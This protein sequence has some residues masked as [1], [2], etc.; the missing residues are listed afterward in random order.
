MKCI[1][2][3]IVFLTASA[4]VSAESAGPLFLSIPTETGWSLD[5][6][7]D[8]PEGSKI[9]MWSS[10]DANEGVILMR[11]PLPDDAD[12]TLEDYVPDWR[13]G[14]EQNATKVFDGG[15]T[16]IADRRFGFSKI[17]ADVGSVRRIVRQV[18]TIVGKEVFV[19]SIYS[20]AGDPDDS[21][22]LVSSLNSIR[23]KSDQS[24]VK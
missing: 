22:A 16:K 3:L 10:G 2:A 9:M 5:K 17:Q 8:G 20:D 19:V 6:N 14:F 18:C 7:Q 23:I 11:M 13:A 4:L 21:K 24:E 12:G 15:F 1:T